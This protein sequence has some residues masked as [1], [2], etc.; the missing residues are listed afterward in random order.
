QDRSGADV[1][2]FQSIMARFGLPDARVDIVGGQNC[3]TG[4]VQ[5]R[6]KSLTELGLTP[7]VSPTA[8]ATPT[9]GASAT[10][11]AGASA[12]PSTSPSAIASPTPT[13]S[14]SQ[15]PGTLRGDQ[16]R[17]ALAGAARISPNEIN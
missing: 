7:T 14:G 4:C 8:S 16:L 13:A 9:A 5:I 11:T 12:T 10:P 2:Q 1:Q 6:A 3:P 15:L 17:A